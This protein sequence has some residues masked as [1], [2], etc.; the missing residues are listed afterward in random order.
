MLKADHTITVHQGTLTSNFI[1]IDQ[2]TS[3][4][5]TPGRKIPGA[6][7]MEKLFPYILVFYGNDAI[8]N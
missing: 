5:I 6:V 8:T 7:Y 2:L 1:A 3:L 4:Y